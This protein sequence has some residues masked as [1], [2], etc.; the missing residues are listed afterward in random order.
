MNTELWNDRTVIF[1]LFESNLYTLSD[2]HV[3]TT[4]YQL[5]RAQIGPTNCIASQC[6]PCSTIQE[7]FFCLV[8]RAPR[9]TEDEG[10]AMDFHAMIAGIVCKLQHA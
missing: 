5:N 9:L 6:H 4:S 3:R 10:E 7:Q 1:R 8:E 2:H